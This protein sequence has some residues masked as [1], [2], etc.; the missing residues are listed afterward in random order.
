ML[1]NIGSSLRRWHRRISR[2]EWIARRLKLSRSHTASV[3]PGLLLI[4]IDGLSHREFERALARRRLPFIK[5]MLRREGYRLHTFYS[6]IP[7]TTP[8][9]Q[10][11]LYYGTKT[12]VPGFSFLDPRA[13]SIGKMM[14][15]TWANRI[16]KELA[17][18]N[19]GLLKDGSSWS[20]IYT[21]GA[22][23]EES[24]FCGAS[25]GLGDMWRTGKIRNL[26]LFAVLHFPSFLRL[27]ALLPVEFV[28]AFYDACRG[29]WRGQNPLLEIGFIFAR[30][31][32]CVGLREMV[33]LGAKVD[34]ARGLPVIHVNYLGYD[35]QAHRRGPDSR[36]AHW[37][38]KG[39][40]RAV[41]HLHRAARRS[42]GRDYE[43]WVFSD[44][45][46]IHARPFSQIAEGGLEGLVRRHWPGLDAAARSTRNLRRHH[47]PSHAHFKQKEIDRATLSTFEKSEFAIAC[48]GPVGHIYYK[49]PLDD[50]AQDK[51]IRD[52]LDGNVPGI[53]RV[54]GDEVVWIT[55][56]AEAVLP[57]DTS[58]LRGPP[59]LCAAIAE[60]LV[61]LA[62]QRFS[63]NLIC[64][65]WHPEGR[66][67]TFAEE[68]GSHCGP[69]PVETQGI[70]IVPP[71]ANHLVN[72]EIIRPV[73]LRQA[74]LIHLGRAK[75]PAH[76]RRQRPKARQLR[77]VT[78]N[79]HYCKGLDGR[80]APDRVARILRD[81]DPDVIA[82][83][84]IDVG[85]P[86]SYGDDQLAY[87]AKELG[88]NQLFCPS[89]VNGAEKYGHGL[90]SAHPLRLVCQ[91]R[92][93][94]GGVS[95]I[96]PR[97]GLHAE[98][99]IDGK[100]ISLVTTH[101][102]LNFLERA[103]QIDRLLENDFLG[104]IP[105]DRP[106][107][108]LGDLNLAPG[109]KLYRRLT[110]KWDRVNGHA[111]FRDVQAHT[112]DHVA[113]KT[114]PSILPVRQLDHIFVT[115]HFQIHRVHSPANILTRRA[116]DHL[117]L[118]ADLELEL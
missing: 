55:R 94:T 100:V 22:T 115:P 8:A 42:E 16:E 104:G 10:A 19:E 110:A 54:R 76:R 12:A 52:L 26:L 3:R 29:M 88:L 39:I 81:L 63:G 18:E 53:L 116:S 80:F 78:Y 103:A 58:L 105:P 44:H 96:E 93:P 40:D 62:R 6:G 90:L 113:V 75:R 109:G 107:L 66:S 47:R 118:V 74:A 11:E 33:T 56:N 99:T 112:L 41:R 91:A 97:D 98:V 23:Q 82:L 34:L 43:V 37:T 117:P 27:V 68:N 13:D 4:Q 46:Q 38:L 45:G 5:R 84:E 30:V 79:V 25:I 108:F 31:F 101:L 65:G 21:G 86:R 9:V 32:V 7:S 61:R 70:L 92:L 49:R 106:A 24:H 50:E 83:Q 71:A 2:A 89:I 67:F 48:L 87:F 114:F 17:E 95:V 20:N 51:L 15:P 60:D 36:F 111:I 35:E 64:L 85:R 1:T 102:G 28:L 72:A 57:D 14:M 59:V 77:V 73:E 69:S